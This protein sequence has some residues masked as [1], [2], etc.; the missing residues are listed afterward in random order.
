[1]KSGIRLSTRTGPKSP[2]HPNIFLVNMFVDMKDISR[3]KMIP[4]DWSTRWF[5]ADNEY[6]F[7]MTKNDPKPGE[8]V[9]SRMININVIKIIAE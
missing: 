8:R 5:M 2:F 9:Q 4:I 1:M 3:T 7:D 6:F